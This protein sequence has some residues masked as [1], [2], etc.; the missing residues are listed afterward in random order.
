MD[1]LIDDDI[2]DD[3]IAADEETD[4]ELAGL[5]LRAS[6]TSRRRRVAAVAEVSASRPARA[7]R[8]GSCRLAEA[9]K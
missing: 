5:A 6:Q 4:N 2:D 8:R 1:A 7:R 9:R 3:E